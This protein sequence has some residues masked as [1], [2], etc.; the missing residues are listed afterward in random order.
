MYFAAWPYMIRITVRV[1]LFLLR[2]LANVIGLMCR[3]YSTDFKLIVAPGKM[4]NLIV[5]SIENIEFIK[6]IGTN[7]CHMTALVT[8]K[9]AYLQN[10]FIAFVFQWNQHCYH[11]PIRNQIFELHILIDSR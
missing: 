4:M 11:I 6:K 5:I 10:R 1:H 3:R 8:V 9:C 7:I 2:I